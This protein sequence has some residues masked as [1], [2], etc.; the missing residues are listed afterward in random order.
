[1]WEKTGGIGT[2]T[3]LLQRVLVCPEFVHRRHSVVALGLLGGQQRGISVDQTIRVLQLKLESTP[4]ARGGS[5][6]TR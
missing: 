6:I 3:G 5:G 4:P 1:L 2:S